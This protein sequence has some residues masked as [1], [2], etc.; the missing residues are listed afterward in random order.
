MSAPVIRTVGLS[1]RF[2][3]G[4][5]VNYKSL[6]ESLQNAVT[7]PFRRTRRAAE[8]IWALRDVSFEVARGEVMGVIGRN[9]AGKSTLLKILSRIT[10]PTEGRVELRG[11]VGSL[12]E[13]GT[14]FH[15]ELTGR[16]NIYLNGAILGMKRAEIHRKFDEIVDFAEVE[17]FLDTPV[18]HYST[19]MYLRLA[20]AVA[21]HL[22]PEILLVD[23]VLAVGDV[24]FQKKCLGKMEEVS[25]GGRTVVFVSHNLP[26]L[27]AICSQA[28]LLDGGRIVASGPAA[29]TVRRYLQMGGNTKEDHRRVSPLLVWHGI[30]NRPSLSGLSPADDIDFSLAFESGPQPIE[31]LR[32]DIILRNLNN[33]NVIHAKSKFVTSGLRV[34]ARTRFCVRYRFISPKLNTGAYRMVLYVCSGAKELFWGEN[35][36]ACNIV[37]TPYFGQVLF[38][39]NVKAAV[40]PEFTV[41]LSPQGL[42]EEA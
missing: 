13:V 36:D 26:A 21:A 28:V 14:G 2:R 3:I 40:I 35:I 34:P 16:E 8:T 12:L 32:V 42:S 17:Q 9:G 6:R 31:D 1:K 41:S 25:R 27:E 19:G 20:F 24:A 7:A 18:K 5:R 33:E 30:A 38:F 11:R 39:D 10:E 22:E 37:A 23:E 29:D 4:K 15:L